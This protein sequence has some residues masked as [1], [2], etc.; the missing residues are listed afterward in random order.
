MISSSLTTDFGP[1]SNKKLTWDTEKYINFHPSR[2][3][4]SA[5]GCAP[6][7]NFW[8][9]HWVACSSVYKTVQGTE[10]LYARIHLRRLHSIN[11]QSGQMAA[12]K[13]SSSKN[14]NLLT[15]LLTYLLVFYKSTCLLRGSATFPSMSQHPRL[16]I[17]SPTI[18]W[19]RHLLNNLSQLKTNLSEQ[20]CYWRW[21]YKVK[22]STISFGLGWTTALYKSSYY[23]YFILVF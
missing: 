12:C 14:L 21:L 11:R 17:V 6:L 7:K 16:W 5:Q 13:R 3:S 19:I 4:E 10:W 22:H 9:R 1:S 20:S 2:M 18:G 15:F 23:L 8:I